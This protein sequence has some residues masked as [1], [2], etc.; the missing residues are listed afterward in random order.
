[1]MPQHGE[2]SPK[3][4]NRCA[5]WLRSRETDKADV[6]ASVTRKWSHVIDIRM[7]HVFG[8]YHVPG[9][10]VDYLPAR[11]KHPPHGYS[12]WGHWEHR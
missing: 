10:M 3:L 5:S 4:R 1:M 9:H 8:I 2:T 11:Q 12:V 6:A 7:T